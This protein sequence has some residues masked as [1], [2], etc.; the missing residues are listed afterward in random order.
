MKKKKRTAF[1][2]GIFILNSEAFSQG[3]ITKRGGGTPV[4][5]VCAWGWAEKL[6]T[7]LAKPKTCHQEPS[8]DSGEHRFAKK[9]VGH[10]FVTYLVSRQLRRTN[11]QT[12]FCLA[13]DKRKRHL[14]WG[15]D[16]GVTCHAKKWQDTEDGVGGPDI[17]F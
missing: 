13:R 14:H 7:A 6:T 15:K 3:N 5:H 17:I 2:I 10:T 1:H 16:A 4:I 12:W 8:K 9:R 11:F